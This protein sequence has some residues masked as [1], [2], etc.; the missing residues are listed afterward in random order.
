VVQREVADRGCAAASAYVS[1]ACPGRS[2]RGAEVWRV[3]QRQAAGGGADAGEGGTGCLRGFFCEF[4]AGVE[5]W[6]GVAV[7]G[8][9][10]AGARGARCLA[11]SSCSR[12]AP[13]RRTVAAGNQ[14]CHACAPGPCSGK[15]MRTTYTYMH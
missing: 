11:S 8:G 3:L 9:G 15:V 7:G 14:Q 2:G 1:R 13:P 4:A 6:G 12:D 5:G 10:G